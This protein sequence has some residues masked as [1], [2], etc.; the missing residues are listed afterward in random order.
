MKRGEGGGEGRIDKL[1][2]SH[3]VATCP[4]LSTAAGQFGLLWPREGGSEPPGE[5]MGVRGSCVEF[6]MPPGS[7]VGCGGEVGG[8]EKVISEGEQSTRSCNRCET[9]DRR[10]LKSARLHDC[11][12]RLH[13]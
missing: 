11:G 12:G 5:E 2:P 4:G 6:L 9:A 10:A 1:G 13:N 7:A 3:L 8:R